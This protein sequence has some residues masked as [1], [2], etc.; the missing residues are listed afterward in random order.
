MPNEQNP[1]AAAMC[2][3]TE[4]T[5]YSDHNAAIWNHTSVMIHVGKV[6]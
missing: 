6:K 1:K 4:F 2:Q 3:M 5:P